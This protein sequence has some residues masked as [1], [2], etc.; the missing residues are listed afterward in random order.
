MQQILVL[1]IIKNVIFSKIIVFEKIW[2][3]WTKL[4]NDRTYQNQYLRLEVEILVEHDHWF[5]VRFVFHIVL[6]SSTQCFVD[7]SSFDFDEVDDFVEQR[8]DLHEHPTG[9]DFR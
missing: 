8:I 3:D 2:Y 5:H 6:L 7:Y 1:D 9:I 4:I